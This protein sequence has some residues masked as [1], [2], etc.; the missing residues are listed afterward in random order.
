ML[1]QPSIAGPVRSGFWVCPLCI[2]HKY[3]TTAPRC[4]NTSTC[5]TV[6]CQ[7]QDHKP[8]STSC[9][10]CVSKRA[11]TCDCCGCEADSEL[12]VAPARK[13]NMIRGNTARR[14]LLCHPALGL[15]YLLP[16]IHLLSP[17]LRPRGLRKKEW[18]R[19]AQRRFKARVWT[20]DLWRLTPYRL[21]AGK[22]ATAIA[23]PIYKSW[24]K[25]RNHRHTNK[26]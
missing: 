21:S 18:V 12:P 10:T 7:F 17:C 25:T 1:L 5:L 14:H 8:N 2:W 16:A 20:S 24:Q 13:L 3:N 22:A 19:E 15:R 9:L 23:C 11:S 26:R 6:W 4:N